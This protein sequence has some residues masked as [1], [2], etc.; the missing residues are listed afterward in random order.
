MALPCA[1]TETPATFPSAWLGKEYYAANGKKYVFCKNT[2]ASSITSGDCVTLE[3]PSVYSVDFCDS[4]QT[5]FGIVPNDLTGAVAAV[6][7]GVWIQTRGEVYAKKGLATGSA[8]ITTKDAIM[9]R[10]SGQIRATS[11]TVGS[12]SMDALQVQIKFANAITTVASSATT[13]PKIL[14]LG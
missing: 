2:D 14:L 8:A 3:D 7:D 13:Q 1:L 9:A 10:G 6:N 12:K 11:G 5:P 4:G